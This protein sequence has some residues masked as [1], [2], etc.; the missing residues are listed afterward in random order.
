[1]KNNEEAHTEQNLSGIKH[2][3]QLLCEA[4][5]I[6]RHRGA[7]LH[8]NLARLIKFNSLRGPLQTPQTP[9]AWLKTIPEVDFFSGILTLTLT[10]QR[11]DGWRQSSAARQ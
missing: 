7:H 8:K 2:A 3:P 6:L 9:P 1:M 5:L 11:R 4:A 10:V